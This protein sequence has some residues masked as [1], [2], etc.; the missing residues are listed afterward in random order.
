A[1]TWPQVESTL[2]KG[3]FQAKAF[4]PRSPCRVGT[5][6]RRVGPAQAP[7]DDMMR[8]D[9]RPND[10]L[11]AAPFTGTLQTVR[12]ERIDYNGHLNMAYYNVLFDT[13]VDEAFLTLG[14]GPDYVA[15]C[16]ASFFTAEV[17]V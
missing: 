14:L 8:Q 3:A 6:P 15:R 9:D 5:P 7:P 17:H 11:V 13:C 12:D 10:P 16:N 4:D 2:A 1:S